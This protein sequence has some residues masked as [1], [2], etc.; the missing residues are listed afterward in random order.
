MKLLKTLYAIHSK[1]RKEGKMIRFITKYVSRIPGCLVQKDAVG[2]I[3]ITKG[4]S[5]TYPCVVAHMDQVQMTHSRDFVAVE[6]RGMIFGYSPK[7]RQFEGLGADDK[8]G[9]WICLKCLEQYDVLKAAF[10]V[11]EEIGCNGSNMAV[12]DFFK[13]CRFVI[14][15]DRRGY[16]DLVTRIA[17][18]ELCSKEF[19]EA[20]DYK[21]F[22]FK[23][24]DGMMT[25]VQ[26]LKENGLAVSAI[27]LSCGYYN[28]H[29]D[30]EFTVIK[31]LQNSLN[32]TKHIIETCT[33][34]YPHV[35]DFWYGG[36]HRS[37]EVYDDYYDEFYD[38][39]S[40]NPDLTGE[41]FYDM[42]HTNFPGCKKADIVSYFEQIKT[43]IRFFEAETEAEEEELW[44][45]QQ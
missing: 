21:S 44:L 16:Q 5:D 27:N 1:S 29:S 34:T 30:E 45:T 20:I 7:N 24:T 23:T 42:Y 36:R 25:D 6:A 10:F 22:G 15:N 37:M 19:Q 35:A 9:I 12:I 8:N 28:P 38:M 41:D 3:Y 40:N 32:F 14:Q 39:V 31:D 33:E 13:D 17:G 43:D 26:A 11:E 18:M 4:T 2:N